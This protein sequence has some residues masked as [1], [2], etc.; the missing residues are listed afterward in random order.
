MKRQVWIFIF[1]FWLWCTS[2][3]RFSICS[4][5]EYWAIEGDMKGKIR[6]FENFYGVL[7]IFMG[8]GALTKF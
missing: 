3:Y 4:L 2:L 1:V 5:R 8:F 6:S 7:K